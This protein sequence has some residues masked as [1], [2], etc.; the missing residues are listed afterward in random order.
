MKIPHN[1]YPRPQLVRH[2]FIC[3]NGVW[4]LEIA[5]SSDIPKQFTKKINV[6]YPPQ[7]R[8]SGV[9]CEIKSDDVLFYRTFF[10]SPELG[11]D[12]RLMLHF[13]AVD[14][15]AEVFLNGAPIASHDGGYLPFDI[16]ITDY[17]RQKN[18][19]TVK[20]IDRLDP[21]YPYGK[22][23]ERRGG[24]WYTPI[25]GIWQSVW[26]E[27]VPSNHVKDLRIDVSL[28]RAIIKV[29]GEF[30][31]LSAILLNADGE[32]LVDQSTLTVIPSEAINWTPDT[33]FLYRLRI[34]ADG[35]TVDTYFALRTLSI[36]EVNGIPRMCLNGKPFF[37]HGLLDQG[38][39][40]DG[41]FTPRDPSDYTIDIEN[42]KSLGFNTL[43][44][45][46]K[47]EPE[48][49]YYDCDRLG[50]IVF[51]DFINNSPY[52]FFRD[53][54]L[55]N[56]GIRRINDSVLQRSEKAKEIFILHSRATVEHLYNHPSICLWTIFNEGWGQFDADR[57][58]ELTRATD[59]SR[60][61]N[62]TSGW[63]EQSKSDIKSMHVYFR[64]VRLPKSN[65]R[66][67]A[68]MEFG[69]YSHAVR[70]HLFDDKRSYGYRSFN[71]SDKFKKA[72]SRLYDEQIIPLVKR[73]LC[74]SVYTQLSD[75]E[76]EINGLYTYDRKALKLDKK[77]AVRIADAIKKELE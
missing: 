56:I 20:V 51:Q 9:D 54:L 43:R 22:Q 59:S 57:L 44:K 42:A 40:E 13:G 70:G 11:E 23:R 12:K 67:I 33:P 30:K 35:D 49:F 27:I 69:G 53:T 76:E 5:A 1:V 75:I 17:V 36:E 77:E 64:R 45:H 14:N 48:C 31:Q 6:P 21:D 2:S 61:I 63:F 71:D 3:L 68:L 25:S 39:F 50:M 73:G 16:D 41:I 62:T 65:G 55:P 52:S 28:D 32:I 46:V 38:Y 34:F 58:F 66:P 19:L 72:F 26:L 8:L 10:D 37:F 15:H 74:A 18:E 29:S 4:E 24:M 60:F 7:S 47:V